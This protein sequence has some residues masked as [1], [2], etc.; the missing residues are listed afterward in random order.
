MRAF[1]STDVVT[2]LFK[3]ATQVNIQLDED[4]RSLNDNISRHLYS[5][6]STLITELYDRDQKAGEP[7]PGS[8]RAPSTPSDEGA[9]YAPFH[10]AKDYAFAKWMSKYKLTKG[11]ADAFLRDADLEA[12]REG[13]SYRNGDECTEQLNRVPHGISEDGWTT[14]E[15]NISSQVSGLTDIDYNLHYRD[16]L[17]V[18]RFLL[19][20][21]PFQD[22]L[23]YA[24]VRVKTAD[25]V[26]VYTDMNT[27]DWW[28]DLQGELSVGST[29][30]PIL[31]ATD[32]TQMTQHHWDHSLWP[33]YLTIGNLDRATGRSQTRP[34]L[35]LVG[36]IPIVKVGKEHQT[37]LT[38]E[39][40]H[41]AMGKIFKRMPQSW[42][43][44]THSADGIQ[45]L[46]NSRDRE[47]VFVVLMV[48]PGVAT[49]S[50][51]EL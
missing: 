20:H 31:I 10:D 38:A 6:A 40:Y 22:N 24:P 13:L 23:V 48:L 35:V 29:I 11:A 18:I 9:S 14:D 1:A 19:G 42:V 49:L 15:F 36:L 34:S 28:W 5:T 51:E 25:D 8:Y 43:M 27:G 44:P 16:V 4:Q 32:K 30:V 7:I 3:D 12:M 26:R 37:H 45:R 2:K 50:L 21:E 47:S 33:V 41:W 46:K 17:N 39:V